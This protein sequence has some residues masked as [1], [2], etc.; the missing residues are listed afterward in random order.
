MPTLNEIPTAEYRETA[1]GFC[2]TT[3]IPARLL[4]RMPPLAMAAGHG[5][6]PENVGDRLEEG[7]RVAVGLPSWGERLGDEVELSVSDNGVG[8][9]AP[10]R[11][12]LFGKFVRLHATAGGRGT[13]LGLFIVQSI[14]SHHGGRVAASSD[15][16]GL[17]ATF[18]MWLPRMSAS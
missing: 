3:A 10:D 5:K 8:F 16:E 2:G 17:G 9:A 7:E 4:Q 12:R 15:G 14:V 1:T 11:E 6:L 18:T 13:G